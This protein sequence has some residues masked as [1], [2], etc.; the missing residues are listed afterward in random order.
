MSETSS[1]IEMVM[2]TPVAKISYIYKVWGNL[3]YH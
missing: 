3:I 2:Q 1:L